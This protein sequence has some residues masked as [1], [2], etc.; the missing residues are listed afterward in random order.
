MWRAQVLTT[1]SWPTQST[2]K[3][4]LPRELERGCEA[5]KAFY[6][7][8]HS[9]RKLSWQTNMGNAG[10]WHALCIAVIILKGDDSVLS[11]HR[12]PILRLLCK[13]V[14]TLWRAFG[15]ALRRVSVELIVTDELTGAEWQHVQTMANLRHCTAALACMTPHI[16]VGPVFCP[17]KPHLARRGMS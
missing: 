1:G 3:C 10:L 9:G 7:A 4:N 8:S 15:A 13:R 2:A 17:W 5:F 16:S 12:V 14:F 6:L 11:T